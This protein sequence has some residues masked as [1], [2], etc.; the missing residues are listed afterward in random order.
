VAPS[1]PDEVR[2]RLEEN[3][4]G[5][6]ERIARAARAAGRLPSQVE[7]LAVTK[8][9]GPELAAELVRLGTGEL[10]E[11]RVDE[12]ER[13]AAWFAQRSLAARWHFV[14]HVQ[15]NKARRVLRVASAI[16]SVDSQR[17]WETLAH[18]AAEEQCFPGIYLQVKLAPDE[19]KSGL[20]PDS[21]AALVE[22]ARAGPLPLLG[23]M[24]MAPLGADAAAS[25]QAARA[26]FDALAAL[27]GTLD[28]GAFAS[29]EPR[30]SMGMSSDL[31]QAVRAG[32]HVVRVGSALFEGLAPDS[33]RARALQEGGA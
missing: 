1:F 2:T 24:T 29:G 7:L 30:L 22:R 23:L 4:A 18:L 12:L 19:T 10:G 25:H 27:A 21:V 26:V 11:S 31:E 6:L 20:A 28:G 33:A 13:K 15:R 14:G 32:S 17:L 5:V 3:R 9:V 16:H 8:S